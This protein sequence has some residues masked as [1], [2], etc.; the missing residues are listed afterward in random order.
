MKKTILQINKR[1][2]P[3]NE[4]EK[5]DMAIHE[6]M[7]KNPYCFI[8]AI[9]YESVIIYIGNKYGGHL[10][11]TMKDFPALYKLFEIAENENAIYIDLCNIDA[12]L[13]EE[14]VKKY[15]L[16]LYTWSN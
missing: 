16:K 10:T 15:D 14:W 8:S 2:I 11:N 4:F 13:S 7:E 5:L 6:T 1:Y 3:Q 9:S 12:H